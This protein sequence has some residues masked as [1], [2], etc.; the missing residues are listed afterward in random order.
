MINFNIW[1]KQIMI[2]GIKIQKVIQEE[3]LQKIY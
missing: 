2:I 1:S 3:L